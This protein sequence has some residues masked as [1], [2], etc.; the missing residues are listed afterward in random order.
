MLRR[1]GYGVTEATINASL[2][3]VPQA[4]RRLVMVARLGESD[5]FLSK[6]I[7]DAASA[8]QTTLRDCFGTAVPEAIYFHPRMPDRR[9]VWGPDQAA[10]TLRSASCRPM[11]S[12]RRPHHGDYLFGSNEKIVEA[13]PLTISEMSQVQGFPISWDWGDGSKDHTTTMIANAVPPP[14]ARIIGDLILAR[15]NGA[16]FAALRP[17]FLRWLIKAGKKP[18]SARNVK[19]SAGRARRMLAGRTFSHLASEIEA[20]E[21]SPGFKDLPRNIKSDLKSG[22]RLHAQ[23]ERQMGEGA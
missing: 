23:F 14:V 15:E 20:L 9:A 10:P 3:G 4:R 21:A 7:A 8:R 12:G 2:L 19:S 1:A 22:L 11:P 5:G 18:A 16:T 6:D 17:D 13:R